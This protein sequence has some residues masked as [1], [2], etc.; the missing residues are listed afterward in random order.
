MTA[1]RLFPWY[2][3]S[4]AVPYGP[5]ILAESGLL[6]VLDPWD[7]L[8]VVA[9]GLMGSGLIALA[10]LIAGPL[11]FRRL[12]GARRVAVALAFLVGAMLPA[13]A[14]LAAF[15]DEPQWPPHIEAGG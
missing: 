2:V 12:A 4:C 5:Y 1:E 14:A 13:V 7:A 8:G 9:I 3:F 11:L 6:D 10:N 15:L